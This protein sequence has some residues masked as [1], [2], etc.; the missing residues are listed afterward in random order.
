MGFGLT[1]LGNPAPRKKMEEIISI[2]KPYF[3]QVSLE[4]LPGHNDSIRGAG[5]FGRVEVFLAMLRDMGESSMVMLTLTRENIRQVIPLA[6]RLVGLVGDFHFNR[7]SRVGEGAN[8]YLPAKKEFTAFLKDYIEAAESNPIMGLKDN[9]INI[10]RHRKGMPLFGGCTGYGCGAAFNFLAVLPDGEAHACRK[11][12]SPV[13]NIF[14]QSIAEVYDSEAARHYR[15][16]CDAC[17][18]CPIRAVCGGCLAS[19][20]SHGLDIFKE[21]DPFCF[22]H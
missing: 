19:A 4:G 11:F 3:Y 5:H 18:P 16:G 12:P 14:R 13:G 15:A 20:H 22:F 2:R 21:R 7:L 10:I 6:E 8:L 9:L 17:R 1:I